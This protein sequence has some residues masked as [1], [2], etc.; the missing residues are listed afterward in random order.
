MSN[1]TLCIWT[2]TDAFSVPR[3][4]SSTP[5]VELSRLL[6]ETAE[7]IECGDY[8]SLPAVVH[9]INGKRC[10]HWDWDQEDTAKP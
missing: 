7:L 8:G 3:W 5:A 9:D 4:N 6:R 10:G 1:F 2:E